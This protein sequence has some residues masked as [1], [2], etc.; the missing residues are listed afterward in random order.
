MGTPTR[1]DRPQ[2]SYKKKFGC[3]LMVD[4]Y[5]QERPRERGFKTESLPTSGLEL[6]IAEPPTCLSWPAVLGGGQGELQ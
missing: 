2:V 4:L 6:I 3:F 5:S 1:L